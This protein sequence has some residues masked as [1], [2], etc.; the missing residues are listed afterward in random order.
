MTRPPDVLFVGQ[1]GENRIFI[2]KI[3][4]VSKSR[5]GV[6]L[7]LGLCEMEILDLLF[8]N[9]ASELQESDRKAVILE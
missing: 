4:F 3:K 9:P 2:K 7:R 6:E 8:Y 5:L 1:Q